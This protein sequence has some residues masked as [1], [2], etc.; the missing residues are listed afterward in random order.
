MC[1]NRLE[2]LHTLHF[3]DK[4]GGKREKQKKARSSLIDIGNT[5]SNMKLLNGLFSEFMTRRALL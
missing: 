5:S 1:R 2:V 3:I 4:L